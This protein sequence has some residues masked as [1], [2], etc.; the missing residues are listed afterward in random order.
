MANIF[1]F[2]FCLVALVLSNSLSPQVSNTK[3]QTISAPLTTNNQLT[4][5]GQVNQA[6]SL[7]NTNSY[8]NIPSSGAVQSQAQGQ[9]RFVT[10]E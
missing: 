6:K 10:Q 7:P 4:S 1:V 8:S 9:T 5:T 3:V 2:I